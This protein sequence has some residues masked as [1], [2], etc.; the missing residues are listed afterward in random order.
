MFSPCIESFLSPYMMQDVQTHPKLSQQSH[1]APRS[2]LSI[3][4]AN[5]SPL[6]SLDIAPARQLEVIHHLVSF[7]PQIECP[8][9]RLIALSFTESGSRWPPLW[10]QTCGSSRQHPLTLNTCKYMPPEKL[11]RWRTTPHACIPLNACP[12]NAKML[13]FHRVTT[14]IIKSTWMRNNTINQQHHPNLIK[15]WWSN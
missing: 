2:D 8:R 1:Y 6:C 15:S 9:S 4:L 3:S 10:H 5:G 7:H 14:F 13:R 11:H 12:S